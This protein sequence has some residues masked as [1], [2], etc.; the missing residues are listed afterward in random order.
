[1]FYR[2]F[3]SLEGALDAGKERARVREP[4]PP[5]GAD[6]ATSEMV[7][8]QPARIWRPNAAPAGG[9]A[10]GEKREA[11]PRGTATDVAGAGHGDKDAS[12][13]RVPADRAT[14]ASEPRIV[15]NVRR[16]R[17]R[18][19]SWAGEEASARAPEDF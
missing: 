9:G 14:F 11:R 19:G 5:R 4:A 10:P 16:S 8:F 1:M 2:R 18:P 3:V 15:T 13:V 12:A 6:T 7:P 17:T